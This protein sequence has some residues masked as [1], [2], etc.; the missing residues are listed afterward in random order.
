MWRAG[1]RKETVWELRPNWIILVF[2][3][4]RVEPAPLSPFSSSS[5][6]WETSTSHTSPRM[7][8]NLWTWPMPY[9]G[10][11]VWALTHT[12]EITRLMLHKKSY[13]ALT[14]NIYIL[15]YRWTEERMPRF[16]KQGCSRQNDDIS[17]DFPA[18]AHGRRKTSFRL[19]DKTIYLEQAALHSN[20]RQRHLAKDCS[21]QHS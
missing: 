17:S 15:A 13:S 1:S 14:E 12:Q 3:L 9:F 5:Q 4:R 18:A 11:D 21:S 8:Q 19:S 10:S 20:G 7:K 2:N 16:A 6:V